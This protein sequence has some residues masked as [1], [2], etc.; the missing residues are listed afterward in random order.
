MPGAGEAPRPPDLA[1][2]MATAGRPAAGRGPTADGPR[3][4]APSAQKKAKD[5]FDDLKERVCDSR[6]YDRKALRE[7]SRVTSAA[8]PFSPC[9]LRPLCRRKALRQGADREA[10]SGQSIARG[11]RQYMF[12]LIL[13]TP[14]GQVRWYAMYRD[15]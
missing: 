4:P 1:S 3:K 5:Y 12:L 8:E 15:P 10:N 9:V 6:F 7:P 13:S 14:L 2:G 11:V